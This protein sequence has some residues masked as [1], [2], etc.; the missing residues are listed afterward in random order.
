MSASAAVFRLPEAR[1][2]RVRA[3]IALLGLDPAD[4]LGPT[5][6]RPALSLLARVTRVNEVRAGEAVGYGG[7][8]VAPRDSRVALLGIGYGDGLPY[9][10]TQGG[11]EVLIAGQRCPLVGSVMMD[12]VFVDVSDLARVPQP[13]DVATLVGREGEQE[14]RLEP[15]AARAGL[16]PY[17]L[18]CGLGGRL[19]RVLIEAQPAR[20]RRA[21]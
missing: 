17:A 16:I 14:L 8:W 7:R 4:C 19:E 5:E 21:A 6:L 18:T 9:G 11:A 13:G 20:E 15:Q 3:G 12:Y 10:W 2:N 1:F